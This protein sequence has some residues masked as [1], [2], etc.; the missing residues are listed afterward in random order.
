MLPF[1]VMFVWCPFAS[2]VMLLFF[3]W[4]G[5]CWQQKH[6]VG[7]NKV[8]SLGL[9]LSLLVMTVYGCLISTCAFISAYVRE[10][11]CAS[12]LMHQTGESSL[13]DAALSQSGW[14][15]QALAP[16]SERAGWREKRRR[17][18]MKIKRGTEDEGVYKKRKSKEKFLCW[19]IPAFT[20]RLITRLGLVFLPFNSI[21][22]VVGI[23]WK[24]R[25]R[26]Q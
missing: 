14:R 25:M 17:G 21:P 11:G 10:A 24:S 6:L 9:S 5:E 2:A 22:A 13:W 12:A 8:N 3:H 18:E 23:L 20:Q 1:F 26:A 7:L 15:C 16:Q 4:N 19:A